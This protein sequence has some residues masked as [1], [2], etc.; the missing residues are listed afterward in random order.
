M[1][2]CMSTLARMMLVLT[3]LSLA[4]GIAQAQSVNIPLSFAL[5]GPVD[6]DGPVLIIN[7]GIGGQ[8]PRPYLFD[9][10]SS[11]FVAQYTASAFGSVPSSMSGLPQNQIS[12][13]EDGVTFNYN[14]VGVPSLTFYPSSASTGGGVTLNAISPSGAASQFQLGAITSNTTFPEGGLAGVFAGDYG[15]FGA[16]NFVRVY[17]TRGPGGIL[18]QAVVPGT[19][20]GYAVAANGQPLSAINGGNV[21]SYQQYVSSP[22]GPQ[23]GQSVTSCSPCV[24]LGLTPAL[25][26][27]F[28]PANE[29]STTTVSSF[30][31]SGAPASVEQ[32][33][34]LTI[35]VTGPGQQTITVSSL[36]LLDTGTSFYF[37]SNQIPTS[38]Y[39]SGGTLTI[40]GEAN[41]AT[42]S[43]VTLLNNSDAATCCNPYYA[44][45]STDIGTGHDST[46]GLPFFLNNSVLFNL[47]GQAVGYTPNFVTDVNITTTPSSPL[48]IDSNS[49]PLGLAGV[50]SGGGPVEI[51]SGGSA[52]LSGTNPYTGATIV[53]NG[54]LALVGPGSISMSS[55][56]SVSNGGI[57]DIS[58]VGSGYPTG[59]FIASLSSTDNAGLVLLGANQLVLTN[60]SGSF[61]GSIQDGG[62]YG[63]AGGSLVLA[64]G[65]ETLTGV[66]TYTGGTI[67]LAG[68]LQLSGAGTL[69]APTGSAALWGGVLDLGHTTQTLAALFLIGG[70]VQDGALNAPILSMGGVINSIGGTAALT[71]FAGSTFALGTNTFTGGTNVN[72]G[73]LDVIGSLTDPTVNAGG[74]LMGSGTVGATRVNT[75]GILMPGNGT[76][77]SSLTI[78]GNLALQSGAIYLVKLNPA[79]ASFA[80][81]TGPATLAGTVQ[82][83][84][85]AG[86]YVIRQY[87]I[88]HSAGLDGTAFAGVTSDYPGFDISLN[89]D[90]TDVFLNLHAGLGL[91]AALN[92]NQQNI[93]TTINN[94]FNFGGALPPAF[95]GLFGLTGGNLGNALTQASGELAVGSQQV[96]FQ[97]MS[98]FM[99]LLTD[100]FMGRGNGPNGAT[101]LLGYADESTGNPASIQRPAPERD[102]Y[103]M[104]AKTALA[105]TYEPRWSVWAEGFGGAQTTDGNAALGSNS[106]TSRIAGTAVG[107]DYLLSP[108]TIAGFALAGGGTN[109]SVGN[110]G[111]GRSDLFQ[112]GAYVRHTDGAAY[113]TAA[114]AYGWQD[115]TAE[116]SVMIAG[117]DQ[118]RAEFDANAYS[119]RV[120]GGYRFVTP[121]TA[122]VGITPY[123]AAQFTTFDLPSYAENVLSGSGAFGLNYAAESVTDARSE[124]GVRTDKSF[125]LP[126]GVMTLRGRFAWAHDYDPDRSAT[127]T[128]QA[129]P[130]AS[131]VVNGAAQASESA[132]TTASLEMKWNSGWSATAS[133]EG[134]FSAVTSSYAGKGVVRYTW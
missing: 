38:Y 83:N 65:T 134:E 120:E 9:T 45:S 110:F 117:L 105:K 31:N 11:I 128:F 98:Q 99:G 25:L 133:F 43:S 103:A 79:T 108:R 74:L 92:I 89:Y 104:F 34:P 7:V 129:L 17:D 55:G 30:A 86:T 60:A 52:T 1:G 114:L 47:A 2:R 3:G 51:L 63:G 125:N 70:T 36:S 100:P 39:S 69:G 121:W 132:L 32:S 66:N 107:A 35:S 68:D 102:A 113:V 50:I 111:S 101:S 126:N 109:F 62:S 24:M 13:Y 19:T 57:F 87:D 8:A 119:G 15:I 77:G 44:L 23:V 122:A 85:L 49:V 10:G 56:V 18:G 131:F 88:L 123:A 80:T 16:S 67:V 84:L 42:T 61:A 37:L 81:I 91:G 127:A 4:T 53:N 118:L 76:P 59:A 26:A 97:A 93:A 20:L 54:F 46:I 73:V 130:G 71:T 95:L 72:G 14:L 96:T 6:D 94:F 90:T 112:A 58:G 115:I 33:V 40:S 82:A 5:E 41:G 124:L 48:I 64:G 22:N 78:A 12:A 106:T 75:G 29:I 21:G 28:K 27:Q 116:R